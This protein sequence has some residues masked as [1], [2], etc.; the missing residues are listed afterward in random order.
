[1]AFQTIGIGM[2]I[3]GI[4]GDFGFWPRSYGDDVR[5]DEWDDE[6]MWMFHVGYQLSVFCKNVRITPIV[7]YYSHETGITDGYDYYI[8][9]NG[10]HNEFH[11]TDKFS[12]F[13][14]GAKLTIN[15]KH[16]NISGTLTKNVWY[17]GIG[18]EI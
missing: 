7:G 1:M 16:F 5:V 18:Y 12:G 15:I 11:C 14:Y 17:A 2:T 10:I 6:Y 3:K 13:D 9:N 4:Y 8:N